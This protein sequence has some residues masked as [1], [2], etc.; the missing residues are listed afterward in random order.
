MQ[1][2][3]AD[4]VGT[5][6]HIAIKTYSKPLIPAIKSVNIEPLRNSD[7]NRLRLFAFNLVRML[8]YLLILTSCLPL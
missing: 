5:F 7:N 1:P 6:G 3:P 4:V 8:G 2:P